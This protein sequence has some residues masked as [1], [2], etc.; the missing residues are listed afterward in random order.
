MREPIPEIKPMDFSEAL[1]LMK[2][3]ARMRRQTWPESTFVYLFPHPNL[4]RAWFK[5]GDPTN[6]YDYLPTPADILAIDW[7]P[8]LSPRQ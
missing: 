7:V 5:F 4:T 6:Y 8:V 1:H 2:S 3:G